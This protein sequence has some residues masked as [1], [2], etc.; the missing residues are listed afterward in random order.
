[1]LQ[2]L[3]FDRGDVYPGPSSQTTSSWPLSVLVEEERRIVGD[4]VSLDGGNL[5]I[6]PPR[7]KSW[8][9]VAEQ[10][11]RSRAELW[12]RLAAL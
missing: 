3:V 6:H 2:E 5:F 11:L 10:V 8:D 9:E 12:N 1:M 4:T 7:E